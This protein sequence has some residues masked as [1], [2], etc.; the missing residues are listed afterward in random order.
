MPKSPQDIQ[1]FIFPNPLQGMLKFTGLQTNVDAGFSSFTTSGAGSFIQGQNVFDFNGDRFGPRP[2]GLSIL[3][4]TRTPTTLPGGYRSLYTFHLRTGVEFLIGARPSIL[5]V[6]DKVNKTFIT[7]Q[8]SRQ[9]SDY[10]FAEFNVN[11]DQESRLYFGNGIDNAAYW[12]GGMTQL[13]GALSGGEATINVASTATFAASGSLLVGATTVT[14]TGLT[15][16]SFTGASGTPAAGSGLTIIQKPIED[17]AAPKGNIY[18]AANNRLFIAGLPVNPQL[19]MFSKYGDASTWS[20]NTVLSSTATAAGAFNL[21]EGGGS[22]TDMAQDETTLYFFKQSIIYTATLSDSLYT[23]APLK[24]FDG[25]SKA[26]GA[27]GKRAVFAS[28]NAVFVVTPDNKIKG[29]QRIAQIDYPQVNPISY[30]IQPTCDSYDFSSCTGIA[31][32]DYAWFACKSSPDVAVNDIVLP[33]NIEENHW[34]A[35]IVGW[36][37][38]EWTIWDDGTGSALY[39]G[40]ARSSNIWKLDDSAISDGENIVTCSR[41]TKQYDLPIGSS[42]EMKELDSVF[43]EGYISPSTAL[44][45]ELFLD[46]NGY[47]GKYKTTFLGTETEYLIG[48]Q[49]INA[50]GLEPFGLFPLGTNPD[51]SG[52]RKFRFYLSKDVRRIPFYNCQLRFSS[53]GLNQRWFVTRYGFFIRAHSQPIKSSLNRAFS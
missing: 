29:L 26:A 50:L 28:G 51:L 46:E 31:F 38:G 44:T 14:Y 11:A 4:P 27:V 16:T 33:F 48:T 8:D 37:V 40:E 52:L 53:S 2:F 45:I 42:A 30:P 22:V 10:G 47:T 36:S 34:E 25:R 15:P 41:T 1:P 20:T 24:P 17:A 9:S 39:F 7:L 13:N 23:L 43:V 19:V 18:M 35:P 6:Y 49:E 32:K 21:I 12:N 5:E 3:P